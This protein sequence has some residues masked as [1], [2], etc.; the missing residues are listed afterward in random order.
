MGGPYDVNLTVILPMLRDWRHYYQT[1][2][3]DVLLHPKSNKRG[4]L[5]GQA[6]LCTVFSR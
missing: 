4:S 1:I 3:V 2:L 5:A 6:A